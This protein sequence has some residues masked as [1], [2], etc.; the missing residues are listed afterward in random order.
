M[1]LHAIYHMAEVP[2]AYGKNDEALIVRIRVAKDDMSQIVILYKDRYEKK[3]M[4][5]KQNNMI[6]K[7]STDLFDFYE[8]ELM[9]DEK[10]FRYIFELHD[11]AGE[12]M[13]YGENG[14]SKTLLEPKEKGN[15]QFPYLCEQDLLE[16]V[17]WGREGVVYQIFPDR[18]CKGDDSKDPADVMA[19]GEAPTAKNVFGG[20]LEGIIKKIDYLEDLGIDIIY[21]TP[22]FES[23]SNHKYNTKDY[24]KI[25][26]QFGD[27]NKIKQLVALAHTRGMKIVLDAVFNHS[28]DDFFAFEDVVKNGEASPYKDWFYIEDYPVIKRPVTNYRT[29]ATSH[30]YM[31]KLR[32][33]NPQVR[34][35]LLDVAKYWIEEIGIDGWRLDVCDEVDHYFWR[36]FRK[37]VKG[38][39]PNALIIGEIM[40]ESTSFLKGDQLDTIMNYPFK[41]AL[42][43]F[44]AKE[45]ITAQ[46]FESRL[47]MQRASYMH[48]V[49]YQMW[50]LID[51]HDTA[52]FLTECKGDVLSLRL[53]AAFQFTYIGTPYIYYG[54]EIGME[55]KDDP[56]CRR[57]MIWSEENQNKELHTLFKNLIAMRKTHQTLVYGEYESVYQKDGIVGFKRFDNQA[58]I[59]VFLNNNK[60][61]KQIP[62]PQQ[63]KY[64]DLYTNNI[65]VI[66]ENIELEPMGFRV[67][68]A[69]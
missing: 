26:P 17:D 16:G 9:V 37:V 20:D 8:T 47:A 62:M 14:L 52:R 40:H 35:Y 59:Y 50:N 23:S 2:Y 41:E 55:G 66:N 10:R 30:R 34:E 67:L 53:A 61:S 51:S 28:G 54:T 15:F 29:F 48:G 45:N 4:P 22:I 68:K 32:T 25:D 42:T 44:F 13:Y 65:H 7:E 11:Q 56:D 3:H 64:V 24:Y 57:C 49:N 69:E 6:K 60:E 12:V 39:N 27:I 21:M 5:F 33:S 58:E 38:V 18:F 1:N 19:W 31:P 43:D 46:E 36:E 63:G